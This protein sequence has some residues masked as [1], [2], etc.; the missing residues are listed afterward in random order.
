LIRAEAGPLALLLTTALTHLSVWC[1]SE[2]DQ[3][4]IVVHGVMSTSAA[5]VVLLLFLVMQVIF[6]AL[7]MGKARG[8]VACG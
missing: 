5:G 2:D 8:L 1:Y 3:P 4:T 6:Q 7:G